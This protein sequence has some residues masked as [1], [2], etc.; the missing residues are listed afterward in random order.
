MNYKI[1]SVIISLLFLSFTI[2]AQ[3]SVAGNNPHK[4][5]S[6]TPLETGPS[7]VGGYEGRTPCSQVLEVMNMPPRPD[8]FKLKWSL[9]LY[10]NPNTKQPT[11]FA[12]RGTYA[13]HAT[14]TGKWIITKGMEGNADALIYELNLSDPESTLYLLRGD[15]N[16]LFLLD[17]HKQFMKGN[18]QFSYTLNRVVN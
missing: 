17:N 11:T 4:K 2:Q 5:T 13:N 3:L 15:E 12:L 1:V 8:C 16:V 9:T 7:V 14:K 18:A 6:R 10:Q